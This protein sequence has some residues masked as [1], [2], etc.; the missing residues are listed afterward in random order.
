M[1]APLTPPDCDLRAFRD[2]PL[3]V[4]RFRDSELVTHE[5]PEAVLAA[6]LLWGVA[7][8]QVPAAS[9]PDDDKLLAKYANYGRAVD[10]WLKVRPGALR[11]FVKCSDGRLYHRVLAEKAKA[12]WTQRL[13]Y[14]WTKANDRHRKAMKDLPEAERFDFPGFDDWVAGRQPLPPAPKRQG[15]LDLGEPDFDTEA[16]VRAPAYGA[17]PPAHALSPSAPA[18]TER[19]RTGA[20]NVPSD[21]S[22]GKETA[23]PRNT[24]DIPAENALKGKERKGKESEERDSSQPTVT[25]TREG[26][27]ANAD[28]KVLYD[29]VC[30]AS[31]FTSADPG[32]ISRA[33]AQIERW[34]NNG[35]DFDE[36]VI[37]TIRHCIAND[38]PEPGPTRTL[39]RFNK[40]ITHEHAR[41]KARAGL[42]KTSRP[43]EITVDYCRNMIA[44]ASDARTRRLWEAKLDELTK[45]PST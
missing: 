42:G 3:D 29:A 22:N 32:A 2:L 12:S 4:G 15:D 34:R 7:W 35:F 37:P 43:I 26:L 40:A 28:L 6:I 19:V 24:Q 36:V 39:G 21:T 14:E 13:R 17:R 5:D 11:G 31:G 45:G 27:L 1:T 16:P 9:L 23:F 41:R 44:S 8:H 10:Q 25:V 38:L 20:S 30:E 33:F 18:R